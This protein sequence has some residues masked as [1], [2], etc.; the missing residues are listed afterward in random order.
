MSTE[1][2]DLQKNVVLNKNV[3]SYDMV[4]GI[5]FLACFE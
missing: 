4:L 3:T 1:A 5:W 2:L